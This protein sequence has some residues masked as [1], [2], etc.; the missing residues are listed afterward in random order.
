VARSLR[1]PHGLLGHNALAPVR[2]RGD[3]GHARPPNDEALDIGLT[4]FGLAGARRVLDLAHGADYTAMRSLAGGDSVTGASVG[5]RKV[6]PAIL[7]VS[8][9]V[10]WLAQG[11]AAP[12]SEPPLLVGKAAFGD[13]RADL[14]G[15]RRRILPADLPAPFATRSAGNPPHVVAKPRSEHLVVPPGFHVEVFASGLEGPRAIKVAPNGDVFITQSWGGRLS[16]LRPADG[17]SQPPHVQ[18]FA[19]NLNAPFGLAFY[20]PGPDP[21]WLYVAQANSV[22][23]FAYRRGDLRA[24]EAP[25]VIVPSLPYGG[26]HWSRNVAFSNDGKRM[27]VSVGSA[28]N[29]GEDLTKRDAGEIARFE[30]E[31]GL[32]AAWGEEEHRAEV[33]AFAPEGGQERVY[34]TGLRNCVGLAVDPA[35]GDLWCSTNERDE[36]GDDLVPDYVTRVR[37]GGFYGWP[38][39]YIGDHEDPTHRGERPDLK[40]KVTVPDVLIQAHSASLEMA[41]YTAHQFPKEYRGSLFVAEHGSWNRSK[42]TGYKVIRIVMK[43]GVPT[44]EYDD[45]MTGFVV[46]DR[47]VWGRPVGIGVMRDGSLLVTEDANGTVWRVWYDDKNG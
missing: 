47:D 20:P 23:R 18:V 25:Q 46:D 39:Y 8:L 42:R 17:G 19:S 16:V 31:H 44:G 6:F 9:F 22:V 38:W 27:F 7:L 34:A 5:L 36:L 45:F 24:R 13:W 37:D 29:D 3:R 10:G 30:A 14:P 28:S 11:R 40:E 33:M 32:G 12:G 2:G 15:R 1:S 43:D 41:F 35:G 21:N 26:S 4:K